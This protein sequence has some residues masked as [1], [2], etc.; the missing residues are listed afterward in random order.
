MSNKSFKETFPLEKRK[1]EARKIRERY[2]DRIPIIVER[3]ARA[4]LADIDKKKYLV[5]GELTMGQFAHVIR[6][7][8]RL[9]PEQS[10][11][12]FVESV[13]EG[14][15]TQ[16]LPPTTETLET[17]YSAYRDEDFF[18]YLTYSGENVFGEGE[19]EEVALE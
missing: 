5:P 1:E 7:R 4:Q 2:A 8:I 3:A 19:L 15:K 11:W 6:S 18:L 17:V 14:K 9:I 12:I 10:L 13:K 16:T